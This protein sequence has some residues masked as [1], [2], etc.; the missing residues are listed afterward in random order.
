MLIPRKMK[1][2]LLALL[3]EYPV[4]TLL[5]PRQAGKTTLAKTTLPDYA[6]ANLE[7][8]ETREIAESD[9]KAFLS[10]F[11]GKVVI[12]EIQRVPELLS[13]IQVAVDA[14]GEN[15]QYILT[16]SHQLSL[17]EAISQ[18]LAG[19]TAILQL[20]P[21]SIEEL[22]SAEI[23]FQHFEDYCFTGF[24]PR[25]YEQSQR[26]TKA[27]ANYY[28]TYVER[29]VRQ[30]ILLKDASLFE[31][32]LKLLAGRIGQVFDYNSLANDVGVSTKTIQHWI[33]ILEASFILFKLPPYYENFGKR[34][35]KSPKYY[36]IDV[37]LLSYLLG[38]R[39][40]SQINRDPLVG[41][42]FENLVVLECLK[43]RY[44]RGD[45]ADIYF[46][47]DSK[48]NEVDLLA[49]SG[50]QLRAIEIKSASTFKQDHLK[51][52]RR[53]KSIT[54]KVEASY[55]IYNG[56]PYQLSDGVTALHFK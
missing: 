15:G 36:F 34:V 51:G 22:Q 1:G 3:K 40:A 9:P 53:L 20:L 50:R 5:G 7:H 11:D 41:Q 4:V 2:E 48:G 38:I 13:Y 14:S 52:I 45:T 49:Q 25:V 6:Y 29:D 31:K 12:D 39:E 47:R 33:S 23:E 19:R 26:P 27:Y 8:P 10:Q 37:G 46:F 28:Q 56:D 32:M 44:N 17:R 24:L 42:I 16:G 35:T 43:A 21:L 18:S 30:L 54:D 55:L